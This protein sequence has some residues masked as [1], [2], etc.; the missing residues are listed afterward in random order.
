MGF[1]FE[2]DARNV[3]VYSVYNTAGT[4]YFGSDLGNPVDTGNPF[5]N[6]L[7][8]NFYGYGQDNIKQQN[9][10]RYKQTEFFIQDTWKV[11][12]RLT[13]D[14]GARFS[15]LG[16]LY[17]ANN[18]KLGVFQS[19]AYS[20]SQEGQ[21]LFPYCTVAVASTGSCPV[22]NKA[23]INPVTRRPLLLFPAGAR[24]IRPAI[25]PIRSPELSPAALTS[26]R[27]TCRS[28]R[29]SDSPMTFS[30]TARRHS[31][32][33]SALCS[34]A[35]S[36]SIPSA[37]LA[38]ESDRSPR[39]PTSLPPS[40][41]KP[42]YPAWKASPLVYTPLTTVGGPLSYPPPSTYNFSFGIQHD[43]GKGF[44]MDVAFLGN[45]AHHQFNQGTGA[46]YLN[47][48][49][50]LTDWTP[51]ANNGQPGPVARYLD[52]TSANGGTGGFYSANLIRALATP[53]PGWGP[54]QLYTQNGE[55]K[56][57]TLCRPSSTSASASASILEATTPGRR[58]W[59][60]RG[61]R[62]STT[63]C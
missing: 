13:L 22:A 11:T 20:R 47:N 21:L 10:A 30:E 46:T 41:S 63:I 25:P 37:P 9:R 29:A 35:P 8:G 24:S 26:R 36:E 17:Q 27:P 28:D 32:A 58:L 15:R 12:R 34:D 23:S 49:A 57:T 52:P 39:L 55:S 38:R 19:S 44:D 59:S 50:P 43:L 53:Y 54:V 45:V 1:Y 60:T 56:F 5:S 2:H 18:A 7:T 3:S 14:Y 16:A 62:S 33:A 31:A 48:I 42:R 61:T 6:A 4:Y 51:T 40:C